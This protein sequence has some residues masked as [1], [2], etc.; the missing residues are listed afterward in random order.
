MKN[1]VLVTGDRG[2]IGT[3]LTSIL[4]DEGFNVVGI[5]SDYFFN[6]GL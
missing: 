2:Y 6:C 4:L 5:D 3:I 1:T